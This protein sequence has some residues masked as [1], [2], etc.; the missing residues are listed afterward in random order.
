M[1]DDINEDIKSLM[2][3]GILNDSDLYNGEINL[4]GGEPISIKSS[5]DKKRPSVLPNDLRSEI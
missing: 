4:Y 3:I 2:S 5:S 1:M